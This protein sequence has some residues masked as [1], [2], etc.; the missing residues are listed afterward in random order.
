MSLGEILRE[1]R[2]RKKLTTSEVAAATRMKMQTV[3]AL[4]REDF[5]RMP[6]PIY[7]KG[8]IKLYAEYMGVDPDPL[9]SEYVSRFMEPRTIPLIEDKD[10]QHRDVQ[11]PPPAAGPAAPETPA[12]AQ[13]KKKGQPDLFSYVP[14]VTEEMKAE[15]L[16]DVA[17]AG[18]AISRLAGPLR[19]VL[20]IL[21]GKTQC[22]LSAAAVFV[23]ERISIPAVRAFSGKES[24]SGEDQDSRSFARLL[25]IVSLIAGALIL[26]VFLVSVIVNGFSRTGV[27]EKAAA[28]PENVKEFELVVKPRD[29]YVK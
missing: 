9:I 10:I 11:V 18:D 29:P 3:D 16:I 13:E 2:L 22:V 1:A 28:P 8:F 27:K 21:R 5:S 14:P 4:E 23:R 19:K 17:A 25:K 7:C 26:I 6:A 24:G 15:P 20:K 12:P